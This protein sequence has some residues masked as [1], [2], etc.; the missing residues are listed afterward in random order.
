MPSLVGS[1]RA[2]LF[3]KSEQ[4]LASKIQGGGARREGLPNCFLA[5]GSMAGA[6]DVVF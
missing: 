4:W 6:G 2:M 3:S 5:E 1:T